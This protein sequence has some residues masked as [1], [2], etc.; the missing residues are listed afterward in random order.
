VNVYEGKN[1]RNVGIVGHGGSG[2]TS[3][4]SAILFD[5]GATNRLGRV[6][7]G[8]APTDYDEEE[9]ERKITISAKLAFC[10]WNKNKI[11]MLDTPGFGNFIQEARGAL[12]VA[13]AAVVVVD[14]VS[15]VMVQTEKAW[16]Y[17][18]EFQLP[19]LVVVNRM[20]R[21]TASFERSLESIQQTLG[22]LCVPIQIPLGAEKGFKGVADLIQMKAFVYQ[23]DGSGKFSESAIPADIA[24]RAQEYREKLV[25][26]VAESDEKLMEKFFDTGS[27]SDEEMV[28][29]LKKQVSEGKLYPI[30]YTSATG[31]IGIQPLLNS[32]LNLLPDAAARGAVKGKDGQGKEVE[33]KM[34]DSEPFSAFVFKTFS[35]PFTGRISLFR[36]Y[37]GSLTTE[38]QPYNVNKGVVERFGSIVVLQG[39]TQVAVP[40]LLAGDIAAVAKLKETQTGDTLCDKAHIISYPAVKWIEPVISFAIEPKSRGDEEKISTAIHKLM[41]EDLGIRYA[42]EPQTKEFL[43]SGQGQMHVE[44][45]VARLKKRYGVEVLLHPPKVPYRETIKGK[46]DVQGKHKKQSGGHGQYGDCKIRMEPLPR[47]SDFQFVNEIFGGAIPKNFIPAVEKGIQEARQK[48]VLAGF[49][50]VD[51]R[52]VL[53]D[54]SYHDVDSSEMAFKIAGSLAFK[55]GIKEAR[56]ILL[57]PVM[58]VEVQG[59]EEFAGDLMGDLNSR[60]G[61][62][63]GMEV[64]GHT[65]IIKAQVPLAEML[66]YA[67]DLTSKTGARGSYSMEFSHYDEVPGHLSDKVIANAKAGITG[68]EEEEE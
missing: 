52:V 16:G 23:T 59:P 58:N 42:R 41:D 9:I 68:E 6:D 36:V 3:L 10:E 5:T 24:G 61:R 15:G 35:D 8:N 43:L 4:V 53:Y 12:R 31:N 54:G 11:N 27:L 25:E 32:I 19:R 14:A 55:K 34:K 65:T 17:A 50:T 39:K 13:D 57:E 47:G 49:P 62:V 63:Q 64:R 20:D 22:R 66:S 48:G 40:R 28:T 38:V 51:F 26:S 30:L 7:D 45:A 21:D 44:M 2:K 1:I 46:A 60:R 67:S 18:E 33:R 37:S 56:P 29:G